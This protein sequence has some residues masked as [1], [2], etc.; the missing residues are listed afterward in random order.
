MLKIDGE[1]IRKLDQFFQVPHDAGEDLTVLKNPDLE[2][3]PAER[4]I[5]GIWSFFGYWGVPNITIWTWSTGSAMLSLGLNIQHT[6]GA[7]TLGNVMICL[8]TCLNSGPGTRYKIGY[9]VCQRMIFGIYGSGIGILI[10]IFL[11]IVF[12]GSQSWLGGLGF[13]VMFSSWSK[14]YMNMEDTFPSSLAMTTRDFIGFLVFQAVQYG[15][16]FL[17]PEKMNKPVNFSCLITIIA[18]GGVFITTLAKN[19]GAG[20]IYS[21][22]VTL[23]KGYTGWMWLYS[24]TIWYGALSP[25][26]TNQSDFSRFASSKK[27]MYIGI[28]SSVMLTGTVVPLMGLL[29]ASATQ[30]LYGTELWLPTDICLQWMADNYS[31]GARAASFFCGLAFMSSQMTFNVIANGFAGGMDLAGVAP[32]YINIRRGAVITALISW[33]TQPWNFYNSS[34]VFITVMS[35]FGVIVTPI[36]AIIVADFH[37]VRRG[38]L[39][40]SHLY[41]T[42]PDGTFY[43]TKGFNFRAIFTWTCGVVP[44]LP[45]LADA[46]SPISGFPEGMRNFFYGNIIF[47]F[48]CPLILYVII[49]KIFP[50]KNLGMVDEEGVYEDFTTDDLENNGKYSYKLTTL[51]GIE[52]DTNEVGKEINFKA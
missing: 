49:C 7:L 33:A 27:K 10:R 50:L 48:F 32:R 9:T 1:K 31:P 47:A 46:V 34:S 26:C 25:D 14:S 21:Q 22:P 45:G 40:L 41:S 39:P 19:H 35:S 4:R 52:G 44:G 30:Q 8:Y 28:I 16:F 24:M 11:S 18:M 29:C 2:P 43:F 17:K 36:I 5:W 15:F 51:E 42:S 37:I 23:S 3:M 38:K 20:P 13:V 12:Y 6:M